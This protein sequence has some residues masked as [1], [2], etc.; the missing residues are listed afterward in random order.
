METRPMMPGE[1]ITSYNWSRFAFNTSH[2]ARVDAEVDNVIATLKLQA[3]H[4]N[5]FPLSSGIPL[6]EN[7][8]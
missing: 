3:S 5:I 8:I 2:Q 1:T 6:T 4:N 7:T